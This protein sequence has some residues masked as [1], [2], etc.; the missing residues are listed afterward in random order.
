MISNLA[1]QPVR[2]GDFLQFSQEPGTARLS[3]EERSQ[4]LI[5]Q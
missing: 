1:S 3:D 5:S 4:H 2:L